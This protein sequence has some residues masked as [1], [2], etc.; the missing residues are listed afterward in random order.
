MCFGAKDTEKEENLE[1]KKD[2]MELKLFTQST[3]LC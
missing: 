2:F 1:S 3:D